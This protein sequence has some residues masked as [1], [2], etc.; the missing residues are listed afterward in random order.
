M[1]N[2]FQNTL[3]ASFY[4]GIIIALVI[5]LR[6]V[7]KKAPRWTICLL[8]LLAGLRLLFP[9]QIESDFSLQPDMTQIP[10]IQAEAAPDPVIQNVPAV[11]DNVILPEEDDIQVVIQNDAVV[12]AHHQAIDWGE[13]AEFVWITVAAGMGLYSVAAYLRLKHRVREAVKLTDNVYEC[14]GLDTAFVLG[15]LRPRIYIPMGLENPKYIVDHERA[16]IHRG[17]H[18]FKLLMYVALALHWFNP[19]VWAAYICLCRDLEMACDERVVQD[20]SLEQRKAYSAA[21]LACSA[22]HRS[23]AACPVAFGEVSVKSRILGVLNYRKPRFWISL[24]AVAAVI[25]VAVCFLTSPGG[26]TD[27]EV[28][29][30]FYTEMEALQASRQLH[31]TI[32]V[33]S[34]SEFDS[35]VAVQ[36]QEYWLDGDTWYRTFEYTTGDGSFITCY[37]QIGDAQYAREFSEDMEDFTDRDWQQLPEDNSANMPILTTDWRSLEVLEVKK[38]RSDDGG[39][40][41]VKLQGN[42]S[43]A[44]VHDTYYEKY[45]EIHLDKDGGLLCLHLFTHGK[46]YMY[47]ADIEGVYEAKSYSTVT[48]EP[49]DDS[50]LEELADLDAYQNREIEQLRR[51][52]AL[53]R[54]QLSLI[55]FQSRDSYCVIRERQIAGDVLTDN[56]TSFFYRSGDD[57]LYHVQIDG[58]DQNHEFYTMEKDGNRYC[59]DISIIH[60]PANGDS[61]DS[62]WTADT[63]T[64]IYDPWL[65]DFCWDETN[66]ELTGLSA[67]G[68]LVTFTIQGSPYPK[69]PYSTITATEYEATFRFAPGTNILQSVTLDYTETWPVVANDQETTNARYV[70]STFSVQELTPEEIAA[71][72]DR[73]YQEAQA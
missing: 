5:I 38:E 72:I 8:W 51:E 61:Y 65:A 60:D 13:I 41:T 58:A 62:G 33:D 9:F 6:L 59:R 23:F 31:L 17:D 53:E 67:D 28:L 71:T 52:L 10:Q 1:S 21:L 24:I 11:P 2:L 18:W 55:D 39:A 44:G 42:M 48:V 66:M 22:S 25:F 54:C 26:M 16:H 40:Y 56:S 20:M 49:W 63:E 7:L 70:I 57:W 43:D 14:A 3:D 30:A 46:F 15:Y 35:V 37:A 19:L 47:Y 12:E 36:N 73:Y 29:E 34:D 68:D 50:W 64:A 32:S 27:A 69:S 45:W 4:G